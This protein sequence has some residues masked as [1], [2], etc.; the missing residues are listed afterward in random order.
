MLIEGLENKRFLDEEEH[1]KNCERNVLRMLGG[2]RNRCLKNKFYSYSEQYTYL[3][4]FK[5]YIIGRISEKE[6]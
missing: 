3:I 4:C 6:D 1:C 5:D 2:A